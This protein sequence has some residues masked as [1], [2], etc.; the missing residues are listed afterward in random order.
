MQCCGHDGQK[1]TERSAREKEQDRLTGEGN[2]FLPDVEVK[3]D[4]SFNSQL[5]LCW[6]KY[7]VVV[8]V[9]VFEDLAVE[10]PESKRTGIKRSGG[11][12]GYWE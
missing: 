8:A 11:G 9:L 3:G 2:G 4:V 12:G 7:A 6:L 10:K 1:R 5:V